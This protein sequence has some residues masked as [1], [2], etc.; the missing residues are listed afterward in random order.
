MSDTIIG[1][2]IQKITRKSFEGLIFKLRV[3][4]SPLPSWPTGIWTFDNRPF[5]LTPDIW[6]PYFSIPDNRYV[7]Y[8]SFTRWNR[9][10]FRKNKCTCKDVNGVF[11]VWFW[12]VDDKSFSLNTANSIH[13]QNRYVDS[14]HVVQR[15]LFK[16]KNIFIFVN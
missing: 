16:L 10:K 6:Q 8:P 2:F 11:S 15:F 7:I 13:I 1:F 12:R 3:L 4:S 14:W 9:L 5:L